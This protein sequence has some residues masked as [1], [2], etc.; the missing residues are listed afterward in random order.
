[1]RLLWECSAIYIEPIVDIDTPKA[2][3]SQTITKLLIGTS[4]TLG[5]AVID[6][7]HTPPEKEKVQAEQNG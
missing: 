1:V 7:S 5:D 6:L 4:I 3:A 2:D